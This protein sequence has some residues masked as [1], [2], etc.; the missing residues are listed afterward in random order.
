[1]SPPI[2][3]NPL[4]EALTAEIG[5]WKLLNPQPRRSAL[6]CSGREIDD[7]EDRCC[8]QGQVSHHLNCGRKDVTHS[9]PPSLA[10]SWTVPCESESVLY[11]E[12]R[13]VHAPEA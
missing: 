7:R 13:C 1:M 6:A 4:R 10:G 12:R 11:R 3:A 9:G 5:D 8:C 2:L